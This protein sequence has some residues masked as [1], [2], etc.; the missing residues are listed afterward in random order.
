MKRS[1]LVS[2]LIAL[3]AVILFIMVG[4]GPVKHVNVHRSPRPHHHRQPRTY[5]QFDHFWFN[6]RPF[7]QPRVIVVQPRQPRVQP[8]QPRQPIRRGKR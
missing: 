6:N 8:R 3:L 2:G 5:V 7:I 4:C 1:L